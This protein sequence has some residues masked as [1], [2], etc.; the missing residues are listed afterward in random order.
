MKKLLVL[1]IFLATFQLSALEIPEG[2]Y[3][4]EDLYGDVGTCLI[5]NSTMTIEDESM[6]YTIEGSVMTYATGETLTV[7]LTDAG[8]ELYLSKE[9]FFAE[10]PEDQSGVSEELIEMMTGQPVMSFVRQ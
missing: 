6:A 10:L 1:S 9:Q 7:R 4:V 2:M 5:R 3:T 8:F